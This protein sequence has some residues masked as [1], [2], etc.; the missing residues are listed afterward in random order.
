MHLRIEQYDDAAP[1]PYIP[2]S[3]YQMHHNSPT[4]LLHHDKVHYDVVVGTEMRPV[5][6][7]GVI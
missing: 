2:E 6:L 7:Y 4:F 1:H 5:V 3:L